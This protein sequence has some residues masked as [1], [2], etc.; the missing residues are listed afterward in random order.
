M[1]WIETPTNPLLKICDISAICKLVK[2]KQSNAIIVADNTFCTPIFQSPLEFGVDIVVHSITK[3]I[4][5]HNDVAMGVAITNNDELNEKIRFFRDTVGI[6]PSPFDCF[7]AHRGL[8]TLKIRMKQH[9]EN[10]LQV[11]RALEASPKILK[12]IYPALESH[13]QHELYQ[14]QMKGF[15]SI[16][17]FYIKGAIKESHLFLD[18]LKIFT[19]GESLGGTESLIKSPGLMN[20]PDIA[21]EIR[22]QMGIGDNFFRISVGLEDAQDLKND[23]YQALDKAIPN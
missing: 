1:V 7:L 21:S 2:S 11:A 14:I 4:N 15:S 22:E 6:F 5:G 10:A 16:V 18:A 17:S 3:Y 23:L 12:C 19:L 8:K 13:P 20:H 9:M